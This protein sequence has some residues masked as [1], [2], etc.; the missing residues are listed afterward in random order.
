MVAQSRQEEDVAGLQFPTVEVAPMKLQKPL[1]GVDQ[2]AI[3]CFGSRSGFISGSG[4][5]AC[6]RRCF[7]SAA[8]GRGGCWRGSEVH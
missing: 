4:R 3:S 5:V 7:V 8:A 2:G 1:C 6:T